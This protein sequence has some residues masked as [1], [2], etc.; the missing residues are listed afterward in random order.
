MTK[1]EFI[2]RVKSLGFQSSDYIVVGSGVMC[3]LDIRGAEDL[4]LVVSTEI[5]RKYENDDTWEHKYFEDGNFWLTKD[6]FEIGPDW[7]GVDNKPNLADLKRSELMIEGVPF[8]SLDRVLQWKL[9]KA[10]PKDLKDAELIKQYM[11][12]LS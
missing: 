6:D 1:D 4:D 12:G 7:G 9:K 8:A 3:A 11:N 2:V 5:F 10:R